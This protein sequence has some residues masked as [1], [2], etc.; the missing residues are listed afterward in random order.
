MYRD[1]VLSFSRTIL[2]ATL[3]VVTCGCRPGP[4]DEPL[5]DSDPFF[6]IPAAADL[7][8]G[9]ADDEEVSRLFELLDH[10]DY[11]VRLTASRSLIE[12]GF[13]DDN[14]YRPWVDEVERREDAEAWRQAAGYATPE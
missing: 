9:E 12:R 8:T 7:A 2:A 1:G 6:V 5:T 11:V 13:V 14:G 10:P 3:L 4:S